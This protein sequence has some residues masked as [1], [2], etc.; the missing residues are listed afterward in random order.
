VFLHCVQVSLLH[1]CRL[2]KFPSAGSAATRYLLIHKTRN[3]SPSGFHKT[4]DR[5]ITSLFISF[6]ISLLIMLS[7]YRAG[8]IS[9]PC[10]NVIS[11]QYYAYPN[12]SRLVPPSILWRQ[13]GIFWIGLCVYCSALIV[14]SR[15]S[16]F[17]T[18]SDVMAIEST[19]C[20]TRWMV[21]VVYLLSYLHTYSLT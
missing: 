4:I 8:S 5:P 7:V 6:F 17:Q 20:L 13:C 15:Y 9:L 12:F 10:Y 18:A 3:E 19:G 21:S 14:D 1:L 16:L 11:K 2:C